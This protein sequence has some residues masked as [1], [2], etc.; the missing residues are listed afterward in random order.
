MI[1]GTHRGKST[2]ATTVRLWRWRRNPLRR[3]SDRAE[4]WSVLAAGVLLVVGA[5]VVGA[6]TATGVEDATLRQSQDWR[7]TYAVL[8]EDAPPAPDSAYVESS[9]GRVRATVR[10][11]TADG[12]TQRGDA[13]VDP[14]SRSGTR[15]TIWLDGTGALKGGPA[16]A[17]EALAQGVVL[18]ALAA[19]GTGLLTLGGL[20]TVRFR[21]D[22]HRDGQ[23]EREWAEID[24]YWGSR[25]Q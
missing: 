6:V 25:R 18:G 20:W 11:T 9:D 13:L 4:R 7:R 12:A 15:I 10:W 3:G 16:T 5:P 8:T 22:A 17:A 21:L 23:W 19:T 1:N 14:G 24:P 2:G